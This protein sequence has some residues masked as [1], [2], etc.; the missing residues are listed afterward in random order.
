MVISA[1]GEDRTGIVAD[2]T[3]LVTDVGG[4]VGDSR[5]MKLGSHFSLMMLVSIPEA[6]VDGFKSNINSVRNIETLAIETSVPDSL[7]PVTACK[8]LILV[9]VSKG[10]SAASF[11]TRVFHYYDYIQIDCPLICFY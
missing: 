5:A 6:E 11:N 7:A 9:Y 1:L 3:K 8:C 10:T 2:M 4:N